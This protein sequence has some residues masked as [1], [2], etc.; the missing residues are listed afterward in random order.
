MHIGSYVLLRSKAINH[1]N[2]QLFTAEPIAKILSTNVTIYD[3]KFLNYRF[4]FLLEINFVIREMAANTLCSHMATEMLCHGRCYCTLIELSS[5]QNQ[6]HVLWDHCVCN[7]RQNLFIEWENFSDLFI[8]HNV[9]PFFIWF[10][11]FQD[12]T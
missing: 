3:W 9:F 5:M 6:M 2:K 8:S 10:I 11:T 1:V 7:D 4:H 12:N